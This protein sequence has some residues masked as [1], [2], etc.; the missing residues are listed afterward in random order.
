MR[1]KTKYLDRKIVGICEVQ[2]TYHEIPN[3]ERLMKNCENRD[4]IPGH[5]F[6]PFNAFIMCKRRY[7]ESIMHTTKIDY[8][9]PYS[10]FGNETED[11]EIQRKVIRTTCEIVLD[12]PLGITPS[13][14]Q[15]AYQTAKDRIRRGW[16]SSP[17]D[18]QALVSQSLAENKENLQM[19]R[20]KSLTKLLDIAREP[21]PKYDDEFEVIQRLTPQ[22]SAKN[23]PQQT[24]KVSFDQKNPPQLPVFNERMYPPLPISEPSSFAAPLATSSPLLRQNAMKEDQLAEAMK[25][26]LQNSPNKNKPQQSCLSDPKL[27]AANELSKK[28]PVTYRAFNLEDQSSESDSSL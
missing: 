24:K 14:I 23:T 15:Q 17:F 9:K 19:Q 8:S 7:V 22:M 25:I 5:Q 12:N 6:C 10:L 16:S 21:P 27:T 2:M 28:A 20:T 13:T 3:I 26:I 1:G 18:I 11:M 4:S